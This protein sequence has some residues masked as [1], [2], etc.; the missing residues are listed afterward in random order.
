MA[1][2]VLDSSQ[3]ARL[4]SGPL[5]VVL[6]SG[7]NLASG[8]IEVMCDGVP[9][10]RVIRPTATLAVIPELQGRTV[11]RAVPDVGTAVFPSSTSVSV[12]LSVAARGL[13]DPDMIQVAPTDVSGLTH[14]DLVVL[15]PADGGVLVSAT[16]GE[17]E[18]ALSDLGTLAR[19]AARQVLGVDRVANRSAVNVV[20][21][22]DA[23][24]SMRRPLADGS[25][26][27]VLEVIGGV[28]RAI[29]ISGRPLRV[30]VLS[31]RVQW[32]G[33]ASVAELHEA[34]VAA[35]GIEPPTIGFRSAAPGLRGLAPEEN[36][37]TFV[38][39]DGVPA[40]IDALVADDDVE[41]EARHLV[42]I[43]PAGA[44][45]GDR[46]DA[47][48]CT[49]VVTGLTSGPLRAGLLGD[50]AALLVLVRSLLVGCFAAGTDMAERTRR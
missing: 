43:G 13:A 29:S 40:D 49:E 45:L 31:D 4:P 20:I 25:L 26:G 37:V 17:S 15:E 3:S 12:T 46:R 22:I 47:I 14:R 34:A 42:V 33:G 50:A 27:A 38:L 10:A 21:G 39:T 8:R 36:T 48:P 5:T 18:P 28:A 2:L 7:E 23:S 6:H 24:V 32:I 44:G 16:G 11:L 35:I 30:A 1:T 19:T 41:G 9:V